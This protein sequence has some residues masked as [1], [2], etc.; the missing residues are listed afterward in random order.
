MSSNMFAKYN[1]Y[2]NKYL[3]LKKISLKG[4]SSGKGINV[5][6]L[7]TFQTPIF[8]NNYCGYISNIFITDL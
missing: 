1:K 4:G 5:L 7:L 8:I 6:H 3:L 2:K